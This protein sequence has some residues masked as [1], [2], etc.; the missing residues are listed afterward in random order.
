MHP[1]AVRSRALHLSGTGL[2]DR[3]VG[4]RLGLARGTV[5]YIRLS[6]TGPVNLC[7]R[8]W[9]KARKIHLDEGDYAEL[10]GLYLGDGCLSPTGRTTRLRIALDAAYPGIITSTT[11]L[12][13]RC[14][15]SNRVDVVE[16]R[17]GTWVMVSVYSSHLPCLFP[18][19]GPGKKHE[20]EI[21]L[22]EW[23]RDLIRAAPWGLIRG[24]ISSDG[25]SFVN[26]TGPYRYL[27]YDF[28]NRSRDIVLLLITTLDLVDV[29]YRVTSH[30]GTWRVRI[31]RRDSVARVAAHVGLKR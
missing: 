23:Q 10:F 17:E 25:C 18:Q 13:R 16:A 9:R 31:N 27:T 19:H 22:E 11:Q 29:G 15:P 26:S 20:R 4:R 30:R 5:Q 24:L 14:F 7:P 8:C 21:T 1:S 6:A 28:S 2:S 12:L 3:E